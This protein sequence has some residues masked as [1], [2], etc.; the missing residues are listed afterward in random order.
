MPT[1]TTIQITRCM[2]VRNY[3]DYIL[4]HSFSWKN[5]Y[6]FSK[7]LAVNSLQ[8]TMWEQGGGTF[9]EL[10]SPWPMAYS[11]VWGQENWKIHDFICGEISTAELLSILRR[12]VVL[13]CVCPWFIYV[14]L[15]HHCK[16]VWFASVTTGR[17]KAGGQ[18]D[19]VAILTFS[20]LTFDNKMQRDLSFFLWDNLKWMQ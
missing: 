16:I 12:L 20:T 15:G 4:H 13:R 5:E 18:A 1:Q 19:K 11:E 17:I 14:S 10:L 3:S 2:P 9:P 7:Y 8:C 6:N